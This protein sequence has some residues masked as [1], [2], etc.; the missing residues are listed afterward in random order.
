MNGLITTDMVKEKLAPRTGL[1]M[2][3]TGLTI[4]SQD[5]ELKGGK[6]ELFMK[7]IIVKARNWDKAF[8]SGQMDQPIKVHSATI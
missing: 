5:K 7:G 4:I 1:S 8:S 6:T 2:R 3:E